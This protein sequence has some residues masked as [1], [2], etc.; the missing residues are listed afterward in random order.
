MN[1]PFV[2][3]LVSFSIRHSWMVVLL[4]FLLT[5]FLGY[6]A[7]Q[8]RIDANIGNMIP[9]NDRVLKLTEKYATA[10]D[11]WQLLIAVQSDDL[12]NLNK[13]QAFD[14]AIQEIE[15][16]DGVTGSINPFNFITFEQE[17]KKIKPVSTASDSKAPRNQ[18]EL[19]KFKTRLLGNPLAKNMVVSGDGSTLCAIFPIERQDDFSDIFAAV[20]RQRLSLESHYNVY[21][22]GPPLFFYRTKTALLN[23]V[24]K[25]LILSILIILTILFLSFRTFRS[26][27][28]PLIVVGF[29]TVW[30]MGTMRLLGFKLTV[31]SIMVPPLVLTLGSAYSIH[32]LNQYYREAKVKST[33]KNWI[34]QSVGHINQTILMAALTTIIGFS[35]LV[36][37]NM[38][39][40]KEFGLSTS[41]GIV[42]CA[43]LSLFFFPAVLSLLPS[44]SAVER[45][46]VLKGLIA[47]FMARLS[48]WVI[49]HRHIIFAAIV[50]IA[51]AF[52]FSLKYVRYQTDY[53]SYFPKRQ[54]IVQDSEE[55]VKR[56]GGYTNVYMTIEAPEGEKN[57][58]LDPDVLERISRLEENLILDPDVSY[59]FSFSQYLKLMNLKTSGS[60]TI[61][62]RRASILLLS[63]Y[64]KTII[65]SPYG[66]SM[67]AQPINEDFTRFTIFL[68]VWDGT[69]KRVLKEPGFKDLIHRIETL[70]END[71][72]ITAE[73]V[74]WGR[75]LA[76]MY[77][78][79]TLSRDQ[80]FSV[81]VSVALI[82]LVT[83]IGFRSI[84]LGVLTLI[85]MM[86]GIMLNFIIMVL[87]KLPFDVVTVM[88]SSV[89]IGVGID[90]S[91]HL[92]IRYRRQLRVYTGAVER[93][94]VLSH[95]LRTTGRPI[96]LTSLSL[97]SG[98][99]VL[100][101]SQFLP[102]LY[103]GM[104]V[105]L[106]L[107][108][109]T[110]GALIILPAILSIGPGPEK[111]GRPTR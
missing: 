111:I 59:I 103:F 3:R 17:G 98:F 61:P 84:R 75:A 96:L 32:V 29:S 46:R 41:I 27:G 15:E 99:L 48:V 104:L 65:S 108:T 18:V 45:D 40:I 50:A 4:A 93:Q 76:L 64:L 43:L 106:A 42:Y 34:A 49:G 14:S 19:D 71:L 68:R 24:P 81:I 69:N 88:F 11:V 92:I 54:Q 13:L 73:T 56:F 82:F 5:S 110:I 21:I 8:I 12:Y 67:V 89:V 66:R 94:T 102:I 107:A 44:P 52:G 30:T 9:R 2:H 62:E 70:I 39:Q 87:L 74:I 33:D 20:D 1:E 23:D 7:F 77:I 109:T 47:R 72:D 100:C 60:F 38:V 36:S 80:L 25:F 6:H 53:L 31:V 63:R 86:T 28:L 91:I 51:V 97:I 95:T 10:N 35:S 22:T 16:I 26:L 37:A 101:F 57:F 55:W 85:P 105:S 79:D 58:F 78:S 83:T 90:D